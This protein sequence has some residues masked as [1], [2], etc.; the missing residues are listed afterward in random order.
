MKAL[1]Y[2]EVIK[3]FPEIFESIDKGEEIFI[4][5]KE[6]KGYFAVIVPYEK[7]KAPQKERPLGILE[8]KATY[9]IKD[10]FKKKRIVQTINVSRNSVL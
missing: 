1:T 10:D 7:Y 2:N 4:S 5:K 9:K 3:N 6:G 8:G